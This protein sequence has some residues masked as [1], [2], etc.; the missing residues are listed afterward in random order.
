MPVDFTV[1]DALWQ[2]DFPFKRADLTNMLLEMRE[3]NMATG[4]AKPK[5][6]LDVDRE[7][8]VIEGEAMQETREAWRV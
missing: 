3:Y 1:S 7:Q 4:F 2:K 5:V 6:G 8:E